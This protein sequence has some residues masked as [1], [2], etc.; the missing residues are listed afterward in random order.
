[1]T[2]E[3]RAHTFSFGVS[4]ESFEDID[5]VSSVEWITTDTDDSRLSETNLAG[6]INGFVG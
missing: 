3:K 6:L 4:N 1:M 5:E 2:L